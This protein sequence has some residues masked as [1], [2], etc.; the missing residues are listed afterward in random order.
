MIHRT[1]LALGDSLTYG[2][3]REGG[4]WCDLLPTLLPDMA[5]AVLNRG[6]CGETTWDILQRTPGVVRELASLPGDKV[7][8]LWAGTNDSKDD[9]GDLGAWVRSY[10]QILHWPERYGIPV[11]LLTLPPVVPGAMH[12]YTAKSLDWLEKSNGAIRT[13]AL[14]SGRELVECSDLTT[15]HLCDGVHLDHNGHAIVAQRVAEAIKK[16]W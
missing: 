4:G 13:L 15:D 8:T 16:G 5:T 1:V 6:V 10:Q 7:M 9:G 2:A 14:A 12:C 3:R 11:L